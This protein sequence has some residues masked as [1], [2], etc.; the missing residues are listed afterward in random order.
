MD[1]AA[2]KQGSAETAVLTTQDQASPPSQ[3][4]PDGLWRPSERMPFGWLFHRLGPSRT[5]SSCI[6]GGGSMATA[7]MPGTALRSAT[8]VEGGVRA[9]EG[10]TEG[11]E[12]VRERARGF[13]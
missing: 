10:R 3:R 8:W 7:A 2:E 12:Q 6:P 13:S 5:T 9:K 4:N 1:L 11:T